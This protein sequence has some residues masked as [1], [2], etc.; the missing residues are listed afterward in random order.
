MRL[1]YKLLGQRIREERQKRNLT[2]EQ[3]S[4]IIDITPA[5]LGLIENGKR[6]LSIK[7][8][9]EIANYFDILVDNLLNINKDKPDYR[10]EKFKN[11]TQ[12]ISDDNMDFIFKI[13]E[14]FSEKFSN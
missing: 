6:G 7:K 5:F 8:L 1:D 3:F 12:N 13:V 10:Q 9:I 2:I 4:E 11:L 14:I